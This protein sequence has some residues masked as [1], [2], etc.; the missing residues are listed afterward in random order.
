MQT[1]IKDVAWRRGVAEMFISMAWPHE[2]SYHYF[3]L[4]E[5]AETEVEQSG[6]K[7]QAS[8]EFKLEEKNIQ[9]LVT[10]ALAAREKAYCRL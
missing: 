9:T 5:M 1:S 7:P 3:K 6:G 4:Y 10:Q 8:L 2:S